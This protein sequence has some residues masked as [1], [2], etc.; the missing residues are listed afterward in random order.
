MKPRILLLDSQLKSPAHSLIRSSPRMKWRALLLSAALLVISASTV[1]ASDINCSPAPCTT[2][3]VQIS[4]TSTVYAA[5]EFSAAATIGTSSLVV[6]SN[7]YHSGSYCNSAGT[8]KLAVWSTSDPGA[9]AFSGGCLSPPTNA[10][11]CCDPV[12]AAYLNGPAETLYSGGIGNDSTQSY[13]G[14]CDV[15]L[16]D[17]TNAGSSWSSPFDSLVALDFDPDA[18]HRVYVEDFDHMVVDYTG[19]PHD[20]CAYV[21]ATN[22]EPEDLRREIE[23][24]HT[25]PASGAWTTVAIY[26]APQGGVIDFSHLALDSNGTLYL[27]Y[28]MCAS[29]P[30]ASSTG[31]TSAQV[32]LSTS[33]DAG[34]TWTTPTNIFD[35]KLSPSNFTPGWPGGFGNLPNTNERMTPEVEIAVEQTSPSVHL[36]AVYETWNGSSLEVDSRHSTNG[37]STW[38]RETHIDAQKNDQ[39]MPCVAD[40][41]A[42]KVAV[43]WLDRRNDV[44]NKKYDAYA[45]QDVGSGNWGVVTKLSAHI[46]DPSNNGLGNPFLGDYTGCTW[47]RNRQSIEYFLGVWP[48][49]SNGTNAVG[50]LAG[51]RAMPPNFTIGAS[52]ASLTVAQSSNRASTITITS[53]SSFSSATTLSATG[54]PSGVTAVFSTNPVTP[55]A[56]SSATS[57]LTLTASAT[58]T[59]GA[60]KVTVTGTSGS[61]SHNTTIALTVTMPPNFT[62]GASPASL[63]VAQSS[64]RASTITITSQSSFSSATTLSATGLPS[65]VTAVFSTNPVTPPANGSATSTLTLTAS[66]TATPG[67]ASI[68]VTG[69]SGSL[70]HSTTIALTVNSSSRAQTAVYNSTLQAPECATVGTS[71]DSGPSLLLGRDD[72]TNGTEPNQPNTINNSCADGTNGVFHSD[73]SNDRIVVASTSGGL[74]THGTTA[75]VTATVWAYTGYTSDALDLYY[76]ANAKIPSWVYITTIVPTKAGAQSLSATFTLPTGSLQAV[77]AQFRYLGEASPCTTGLY[78]DHDDLIFAVQ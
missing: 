23:V 25:C 45:A 29:S 33:A 40:D 72:L 39:F 51:Y 21:S 60:A 64:N 53:Q 19:G 30:C 50:M 76:A 42:G 70:S 54:L 61:L 59:T 22:V 62:I 27:T 68:T 58:A 78:N 48:D 41:G 8:S 13:C 52:P 74:L 16:R 14:V 3:N 17:S 37:G 38:G 75:T 47:W 34:V 10:V 24:A 43:L 12:S 66:A 63:T 71:C 36:I 67:T 11:Y 57:T 56:N 15:L 31:G 4:P 26:D 35:I 55:P 73:E 7:Y 77:R 28:I 9:V 1:Q 6:S 65:G 20:G 18:D 49:T 44:S 46:S 2:A 69:T 32:Y 5:V